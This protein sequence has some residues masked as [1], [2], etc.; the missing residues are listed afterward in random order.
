M[1]GHP[2]SHSEEDGPCD[3][4]VGFADDANINEPNYC[5]CLDF[6]PPPSPPGPPEHRRSRIALSRPV[7]WTPE[8]MAA[9]LR[10]V[11]PR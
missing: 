8:D 3:Y 7:V 11:H 5:C 9:A 1:C 4:I 2:N 10:S 6:I